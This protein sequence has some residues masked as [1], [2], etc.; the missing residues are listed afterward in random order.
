[1]QDGRF[2]LLAFSNEAPM[3]IAFQCDQCGK[4]YEAGDH[5][6]GKALKCK[7]CGAVVRIPGTA[8]A[9]TSPPVTSVKQAAPARPAPP[10]DLD[11]YGLEDEPTSRRNGQTVANDADEEFAPVLPRAGA[12]EPPSK[13]KSK[14]IAKR[15]AK[16]D[17]RKESNAGGAMKLS[18]GTA[19]FVTMLLVRFG[20]K[21]NKEFNKGADRGRNLAAATAPVKPADLAGPIALP[22]L[23][24]LGPAEELEPGVLFHEVTLGTDDPCPAVPGHRG[25][26]WLYLPAGEHAPGSLPCVLITGAGSNLISGMD[27]SEGDM[28]EHIP[29]VKAG[30]AVM[31]FELDGASD[32][33][34]DDSERERTMRAFV[35]ARAGLV[36]AHIALEYLLAKVPQV[37]PNQLYA[38]GH[39]SAGTLALLFAEHE[40]KLKGCVAF[41]P[42]IDVA[43]R[44]GFVG[45]KY[46]SLLPG[47]Q[48]ESLYTTFSP[49]DNEAG[50]SCPL[51]LFHAL[52]DSNIPAQE[53]IDC[54][55]RLKALGKPVTLETVPTGD[56]Y[57]SMISQGVPRAVAW[58]NQRRAAAP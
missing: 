44:L 46:V 50:L 49:K 25:V 11:L 56:H 17:K 45:R 57:Q 19:F 51:L 27:L 15:A 12:Y 14:K 28:A 43:Q 40:P 10:P 6:A 55:A 3:S 30:F 31:A 16:L 9:R 21:L 34:D 20:L 41:A 2:S 1:M 53:S 22:P 26:L 39:S 35:A 36:N 37:N 58:L 5:L 8:A 4:H 47:G 54:A 13:E 48:G 29:Y 38:V 23:P 24:E 32:D 42:C 33:P 52:D 7:E 18:F